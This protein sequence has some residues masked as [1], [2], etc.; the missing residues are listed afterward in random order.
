MVLLESAR[1]RASLSK[2]DKKQHLFTWLTCRYN[3]YKSIIRAPFMC[4]VYINSL[5]RISHVVGV[6]GM[7]LAFVHL[8]GFIVPL[9]FVFVECFHKNALKM[10]PGSGVALLPI[11]WLSNSQ[12]NAP[13]K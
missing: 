10:I 1:E 13:Y 11:K 7:F 3:I 8:S 4:S 2:S 9:S 5:W 6:V 12:R